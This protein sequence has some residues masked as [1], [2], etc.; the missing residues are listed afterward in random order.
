[1]I[2]SVTAR[3]LDTDDEQPEGYLFPSLMFESSGAWQPRQTYEV[4][5]ELSSG[6]E[7]SS[8]LKYPYVFCLGRF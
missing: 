7:V 2:F 5:S 8:S 3:Q 4:A 1:M 6:S